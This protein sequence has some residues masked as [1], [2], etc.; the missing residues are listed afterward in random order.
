ML[1][2]IPA[3]FDTFLLR[4]TY[5]LQPGPQVLGITLDNG[6]KYSEHISKLVSSFTASLCQINR[7]KYIFYKKTLVR[8]ENVLVFSK[9]LRLL[10]Y[11]IK[12]IEEKHCKIAK[13]PELCCTHSVREKEIW[14]Y[15]VVIKT[16]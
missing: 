13:G 5:F 9:L 7:T 10:D 14:S 8:I 6:L 16:A 12:Y 11:M 2:Q 1:K 15:H 3:N 4:K